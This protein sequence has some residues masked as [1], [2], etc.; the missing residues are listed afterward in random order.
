[1]AVSPEESRWLGRR[2]CAYGWMSFIFSIDVGAIEK[3]NTIW[4]KQQS[5]WGLRLHK[6][7]QLTTNETM[8]SREP[9]RTI[10]LV[11]KRITHISHELYAHSLHN[12]LSAPSWVSFTHTHTWHTHARTGTH[13]KRNA[14]QMCGF[15]HVKTARDMFVPFQIPSSNARATSNLYI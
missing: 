15:E 5:E 7:S 4:K 8:L 14:A 11:W 12:F 1:M 6:M 2:L 10:H 13:S 3:K 9:F